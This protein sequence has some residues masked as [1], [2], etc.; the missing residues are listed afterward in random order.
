MVYLSQYQFVEEF[1][2]IANNSFRKL[3]YKQ[4][5]RQ[6]HV[7]DGIKD[8]EPGKKLFRIEQKYLEKIGKGSVS[9]CTD[10]YPFGKLVKS[11]FE[12]ECNI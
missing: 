2:K 5:I 8:I 7:D 11:R 6:L 1:L 10:T 3:L 12:R 4:L 9:F